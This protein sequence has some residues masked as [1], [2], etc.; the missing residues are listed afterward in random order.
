MATMIAAQTGPTAGMV[1]SNLYSFGVG[2]PRAQGVVEVVLGF[3]SGVKNGIHGVENSLEAGPIEPLQGIIASIAVSA[4]RD[5]DAVSGVFVADTVFGA[6]DITD[7]ILVGA[8]E[9][10]DFLPRTHENVNVLEFAQAQKAG[11]APGIHIVLRLGDQAILAGFTDDD[12]I[13]DA[14][15]RF[16]DENG[17]AG[18]FDYRPSAFGQITGGGSQLL[19]VGGDVFAHDNLAL[20]VDGTKRAVL[21]VG[22][23]TKKNDRR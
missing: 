6:D 18:G 8:N 17:N 12:T 16:L 19:G 20:L 1:F 4:V 11:E 10:P 13:Q 21:T 9:L 14:C 22:V 2:Q 5:L 23:N 15:Q 3:L 7:S